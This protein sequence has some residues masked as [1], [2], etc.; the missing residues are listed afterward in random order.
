M[1]LNTFYNG[2]VVLITGGSM[3]IG[4][5]LAKLALSYGAKVAITGRTLSKLEFVK[6]EFNVSEQNIL[7]HAGD[8]TDYKN[9]QELV[10]KCIDKFGKID[11]LINN[12]GLSAFGSIEDIK[13]EVYKTVVDTNIYGS[14]FPTKACIPSLKKVNGSV[15]FVSSIAGLTGLPDYSAYSLSKMSLRAIAHA[16][17]IEL[18]NTNVFVGICYV[19]FTENEIT[20]KTYSPNGELIA[21][22][23]RPS[24][25][26]AT[27]EQTA[28]KMLKQIK[29]K[30]Y[31][32]N[33]SI[34]G[35]LVMFQSKVFPKLT[36]WIMRLNYKSK[37]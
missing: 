2:K 21:I 7:I 11:V 33:Q 29:R 3:G 24:F 34:L 18:K 20:K 28:K 23:K 15:L 8:V 19:G 10:Q 1:N 6:K 16:L 22:P 31:S 35:N 32:V 5:E 14:V 25:L 12:A 27:R 37:K 9:N 30:K 13:P 4:K 36:A 26:T 17:R